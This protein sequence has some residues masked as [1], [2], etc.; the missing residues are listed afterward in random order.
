KT[1]AKFTPIIAVVGTPIFYLVLAGIFALGMMFIQAKTT[2]KKILSV[3]AWSGAVTAL[4][5]TIVT[6]IALLL[7]DK[8]S[9]A[10][11]DP[12][13]SSGIVPTNVGAFLPSDSSPIIM[14]IA[15]SLD[16]FSIWYLILLSIGLAAIAGARKIT[17]SKTGG[18][19]FGL[20]AVF[21]LI[22]VVWAS[23]FG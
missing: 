11:I 19:V 5:A 9:L 20:W 1:F 15:S 7:Q 16:I 23:L 14:A 6:I 4:I 22:K 13:K 18:L 8:E 12:T 2:F 10:G 17:T 3:V 21:V